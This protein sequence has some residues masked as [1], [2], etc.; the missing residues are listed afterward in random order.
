MAACQFCSV[1]YGYFDYIT[2]LD[3]ESQV[4]GASS[5]PGPLKIAHNWMSGGSI[6]MLLGGLASTNPNY[7]ANDIEVRQ[8]RFTNPPSWVGAGY[9]GP[10]LV[11]KNRQEFKTCRRCLVDGNIAEYVDTSGAQQGQCFTL[12]PRS[13][14]AGLQCDNY[15]VAI[16]D[17]T[18]SN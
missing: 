8:N 3:S 13:C 11:I 17:V 18:F 10:P 7:Y 15:Q 4:I 5:T 6:A 9:A 1:T 14:S 12:T 16:Q 2:S